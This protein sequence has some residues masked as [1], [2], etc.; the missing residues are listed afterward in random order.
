MT[1]ATNNAAIRS[2][3]TSQI[4]GIDDLDGLAVRQQRA[5]ATVYDTEPMT[6]TTSRSATRSSPG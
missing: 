2:T 6:A 3:Y 5:G 4:A 1:L